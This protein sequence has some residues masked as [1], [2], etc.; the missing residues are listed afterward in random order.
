VAGFVGAL[1]LLFVP[2]FVSIAWS[3]RAEAQA[4]TADLSDHLI[5]IT[6]GFT[7][8]N[9]VLFGATEGVGDIILVVTGPETHVTL[10]RKGQV[11]GIWLNQDQV[12][13]DRIPSFY[14]VASSQPVDEIMKRGLRQLH[15]VGLDFLRLKATEKDLDPEYVKNFR[16]ALIDLKQEQGLYHGEH[17]KVTFL[18]QHLFRSELRF[19]S[20]VPP[21]KYGIKI[22]LLKD[23]DVVSASTTP[24]E[25]GK[26]G[27]G[28]DIFQFAHQ[29]AALYGLVAI[30]LA[31]F[32]GWTADSIFNRKA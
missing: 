18:G 22:Y 25:I 29:H 20:N 5:R 19:P 14:Y 17:G 31:L 8:A 21:G 10:R 12:A 3:W 28:A 16:T 1:F 23:G 11:A 7:G 24:L 32:A 30:I 26:H 6:A 13:F 15:Q 4:L 2:L 9:V 27:V